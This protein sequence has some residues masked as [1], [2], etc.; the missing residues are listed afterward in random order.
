MVDTMT[1]R[2]S[3]KDTLTGNKWSSYVIVS[4]KRNPIILESSCI[5]SDRRSVKPNQNVDFNRS[6]AK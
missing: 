5:E 1:P 4:V 3:E 6:T 2:S